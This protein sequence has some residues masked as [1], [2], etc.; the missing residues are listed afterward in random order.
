MNNFYKIS[1]AVLGLFFIDIHSFAQ[2]PTAASCSPSNA[3]S[4]NFPL[5]GGIYSLTLGSVSR[6]SPG[7]TDCYQD[8]SCTLGTAVTAGVPLAI[9]LTT[10]SNFN[11]NVKV[12]ID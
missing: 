6:T 10:G 4:G 7:V 3:P 8:L 5:Q 12:W 11:E 1:F 9:A 2:C